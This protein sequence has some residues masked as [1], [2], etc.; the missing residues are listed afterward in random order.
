MKLECQHFLD[1]IRGECVPIAQGR[2]G[3]EV[4]RILEAAGESL[5]QR[6]ASVG[7]EALAK[8][9]NGNCEGAGRGN[10]DDNGRLVLP[11]DMR[12]RLVA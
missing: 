12:V 7:V 10:K 2:Q 3:L 9:K 8:G 6:G 5:R 4:M 1:C 11:A